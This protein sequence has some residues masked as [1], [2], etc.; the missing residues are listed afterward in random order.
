MAFGDSGRNDVLRSCA[1]YYVV[2]CLV[3][4]LVS[5]LTNLQKQELLETWI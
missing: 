3:E 5:F 1:E 2:P 4:K